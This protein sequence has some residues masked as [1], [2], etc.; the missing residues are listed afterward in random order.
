MKFKTSASARHSAQA[1]IKL[2]RLLELPEADFARRVRELE[3]DALFRSLL[4][5]QVVTV[6]PYAGAGFAA[7]RFGGWGL[8]TASD[9]VPALDGRGD[10]A[11]LLQRVGQERFEECFL[12]EEKL[13]DQDRARLCGISKEEAAR[14]PGGVRHGRRGSRSGEDL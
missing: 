11:K 4:D 3:A 13:S 14:L 7:R 6:Q 2:A 1:G 10:L 5:A 8:S 9:G 12:G